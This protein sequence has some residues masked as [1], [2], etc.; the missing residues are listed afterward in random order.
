MSSV[1]VTPK[2]SGISLNRWSRSCW[3][4]LHSAESIPVELLETLALLLPC[5]ICG[6]HMR[7]FLKKHPASVPVCEWVVDLHNDVNRRAGKAMYTQYDEAQSLYQHTDTRAAFYH[8][9]FAISFTIRESQVPQFRTFCQLAFPTVGLEPPGPVAIP[10]DQV[11]LALYRYIQPYKYPTFNDL[12]VDFVP[13]SYYGRYGLTTA[14]APVYTAPACVSSIVDVS[15]RS[16]IHEERMECTHRVRDSL[17]VT[18]RITERI[19]N[20]GLTNRVLHMCPRFVMPVLTKLS[21]EDTDLQKSLKD[22][23]ST[24]TIAQMIHVK[25]TTTAPCISETAKSMNPTV[26]ICVASIVFCITLV[27]CVKRP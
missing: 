13:V 16:I 7:A 20:M 9:V 24:D 17:C 12:V 11:P 8:F 10:D 27:A 19:N 23:V 4:W 2:L 14:D 1:T 5:T 18:R 25:C 21:A 15:I 22:D 26:G 6:A 3:D